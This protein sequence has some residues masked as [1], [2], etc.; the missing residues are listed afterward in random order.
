MRDGRDSEYGRRSLVGMPDRD[1]Y[2]LLGVPRGASEEDLRKAYRT[3]ARRHHPDINPDDPGAEDRF[4]EI[5]RAYELLSNPAKRRKYDESSRATSQRGRGGSRVRT[6][7]TS[8]NISRE[9]NLED[10][11]ARLRDRSG[12][13]AGGT[14]E[15]GGR[16]RG[17][18]FGIAKILGVDLE[19][20]AKLASE[21]SEA[22]AQVTFG[23]GEEGGSDTQ[24]ANW[25]GKK[26]HEERY[27]KPPIPPK[28]PIPKKP[29]K[30]PKI[31]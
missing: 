30:P 22:R 15:S 24:D 18:V 25:P 14:K 23:H 12:G 31:G 29:P 1:P 16:L 17:D 4:K 19:R 9:I 6:G 28:P 27:R 11:L 3:L 20:L 21:A 8:R 5:Q 7:K 2:Q 10:L 13:R 26:P